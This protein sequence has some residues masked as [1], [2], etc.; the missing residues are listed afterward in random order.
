[1][2]V[3]QIGGQG[4]PPIRTI[5][6]ARIIDH[7]MVYHFAWGF[8]GMEADVARRE[9]D[10]AID[11]WLELGLGRATGPD[12]A[13]LFDPVE[14]INFM[15]AAGH[16]G[17]DPFWE[18]NYV[19]A[20]RGHFLVQQGMPADSPIAPDI[21]SLPPRRFHV[22]LERDFNLTGF[23]ADSRLRLRLPVPIEDHAIR[24]LAIDSFVPPGATARL[25]PARLDVS[26]IATQPGPLTIALDARFAGYVDTGGH[27]T[28]S[29]HE[30]DIYTRPREMLICV[31][32]R[33]ADLARRLTEGKRDAWARVMAIFDY[34]LDNF[35]LGAVP[36]DALDPERPAD[37]SFHTG[38]VDCHL[39]AALLCAMCRSLG[40]PAR[41]ANGYMLF[42][43]DLAYHYW[44]E[45]W[46][47]ERGWVGFDSTVWHLSRGGRDADWRN[48]MTGVLDYRVKTQVFPDL[49]TGPSTLRLPPAWRLLSCRRDGFFQTTFVDAITGATLYTDRL[50]SIAQTAGNA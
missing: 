37:W 36:Y 25:Q 40:I 2:A 5:D 18:Q 26:L 17:V 50:V 43:H 44:A 34:L 30:R 22:R 8:G 32:D 11:A 38:I 20:Q 23:A 14:V 4:A 9:I 49:F 10:A 41:L 1:M 19:A 15:I 13:H 42:P 16:R 48:L 24:D 28:L 27:G 21:A 29:A 47:E 7:L 39:S 35:R 6:R 3:G 45:I 46:I 12:G 33:A 31:D